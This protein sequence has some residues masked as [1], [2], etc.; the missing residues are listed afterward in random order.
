MPDTNP[1]RVLFVCMGN[2][3]RSPA[4]EAVLRQLVEDRGLEEVVEIDSAGTIGYHAGNPPDSRMS[5]SGEERGIE[6]HGQARQVTFE[7]LRL[8]DRVI[9]LDQEN[10]ADLE[11]L[12]GGSSSHIRLLSSYLPVGSLVD[13]PD[14]YYGGE[15]GFRQVLDMLEEAAPA[16]LQDLESAFEQSFDS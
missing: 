4:A 13:V 6:I 3:C 2:I 5:Q 9:A 8:F 7:D 14:P 10:L 12:A 11:S 15:A 16:I 1:I